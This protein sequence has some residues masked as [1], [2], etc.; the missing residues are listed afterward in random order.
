MKALRYENYFEFHQVANGEKSRLLQFRH[1]STNS[2][3]RK[4][5]QF[6]VKKGKF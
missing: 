4:I 3:N 1:V 6:E 5:G 2:C